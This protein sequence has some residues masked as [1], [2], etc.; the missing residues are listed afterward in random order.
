M[1]E[2]ELTAE[3]KV[4]LAEKGWDK[5]YVAFGS[6]ASE[7]TVRLAVAFNLLGKPCTNNTVA[8]FPNWPAAHIK[9]TSFRW[10]KLRCKPPKSLFQTSTPLPL[11]K[12]PAS[13][14]RLL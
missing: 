14:V 1:S 6:T 5:G 3:A 10:C 12:A 8:W 4:L 9:K 13:W 11:R 7:S 2:V